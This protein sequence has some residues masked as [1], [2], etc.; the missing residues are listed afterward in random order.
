MGAIALAC[1]SKSSDSNGTTTVEPRPDSG[2]CVTECCELPQANAPCSVDAG[3]TCSFAATCSEGLV[4]ARTTMCTGGTWQVVNDCPASGLTDARGCP[5][6]QPMPGTP[7][8]PFDGGA[9]PTCGYSKTCTGKVCDG[10]DCVQIQQAA[11]ATC[12]NGMWTTTPL[13]PC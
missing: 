13:G 10:G 6:A 9:L 2:M 12:V 4:L 8:G 5:A 11:N 1:S 7:C 3:T